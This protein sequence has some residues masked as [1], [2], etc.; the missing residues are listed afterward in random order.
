MASRIHPTAIIEAG[1]KL[2][3]DVDIGAY[4]FVGAGVTIGRGTRLQHHATVEGNT[5]LG[6]DCDIFPY[7]CLGAKTQDL[8]FKGGNPGV[9]IGNRNVFREFTSVHAATDDGKFTTVGSDNNFLAYTH[10][11]HDCIVGNRVIMSNYAGLAGHVTVEDH[12]VIGGYGGVHQFCRVGTHAMVAACA[13]VVQ[14]V[15]PFFIADGSPATARAINKVGLERTGYTPEQ[16]DRVKLIHR[17]LYR[18]GLN[19]SQALE[20]L[21]ALP[22]ATSDEIRRVLD[23][24]KR[25]DRGLIT[26]A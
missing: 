17:I 20:K 8:K 3:A 1:A 2:G 14:D 23:F 24:A 11:A 13:K 5:V 16:I 26:G 19:R 22:S 25:S 18:E 7:A 12:V 4:A 15:P 10:I 6:E 21:E 9:R